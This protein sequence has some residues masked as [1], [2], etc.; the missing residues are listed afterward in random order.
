MDLPAGLHV[1]R[2][3]PG[4]WRHTLPVLAKYAAHSAAKF[5]SSGEEF[6]AA[7]VFDRHS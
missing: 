5:R 4:E 1:R 3:Q 6:L 7:G 2:T